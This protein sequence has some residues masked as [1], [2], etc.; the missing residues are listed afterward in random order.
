METQTCPDLFSKQ[1][2][3]H[4]HPSFQST[5]SAAWVNELPV[6]ADDISRDTERSFVISNITSISLHER[7]G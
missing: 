1:V 7:M 2:T 5:T 4:L 3:S 6:T